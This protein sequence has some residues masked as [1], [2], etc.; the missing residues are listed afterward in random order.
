[1]IRGNQ[2][3]LS[4][5]YPC[6]Q[7]M[8]TKLHCNHAEALGPGS[9]NSSRAQPLS[10]VL[11]LICD[12]ICVRLSVVVSVA[13]ER[14]RRTCTPTGRSR[15]AGSSPSS[16]CSSSSVTSASDTAR[17]AAGWCV[18][19]HTCTCAH[20]RISESETRTHTTQAHTHSLDSHPKESGSHTQT[21]RH[22]HTHTFPQVVYD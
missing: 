3:S 1:M 10:L 7:P 16:P 18:L 22:T 6:Q 8:A 9:W 12:A 2:V 4:P 14:R 15:L 20:T 17:T 21:H 11:A 5:Q 13:Q 19:T